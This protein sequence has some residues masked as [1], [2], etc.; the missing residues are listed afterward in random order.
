MAGKVNLRDT[1]L[2]LTRPEPASRRFSRQVEEVI[3]IFAKTLIAP[4]FEI[5]PL[6]IVSP[7][8]LN[9]EIAFT[10]ENGVRALSLHQEAGGRA[11]WCVGARTAERAQ[12]EGY[13]VRTTKPTVKSLTEALIEDPSVTAIVHVTGQ[14]RRGDLA[15]TLREAGR[16]ARTLIVYDQRALPLRSEIHNILKKQTDIVAPV[17]SPRSAD[18]LA[19]AVE[20]RKARIHL[21]AISDAT[22]MAWS[23]RPGE[24]VLIAPSP[25]AAGILSAMGS[26][27]DAYPSA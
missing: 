25:D 12:A 21:V 16:E 6:E 2:L 14:H 13:S 24:N 1:T 7:P 8:G 23:S 15:E 10:S 17:F 3:G 26:L 20:H 9:E 11:A 5:V 19:G 27:F 22:A 18:L 4:L